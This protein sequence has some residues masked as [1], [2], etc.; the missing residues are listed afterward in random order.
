MTSITLCCW[1]RTE[2]LTRVLQSLATSCVQPYE[3]IVVDDASKN[4]DVLTLVYH[5]QKLFVEQLKVPF[6]VF[7]NEVNRGHAASQNFAMDNAVGDVL[8][9]LEDDT[10]C[11]TEGWNLAM[12]KFLQDHPEVGQV[13]PEGS[14]R[15][16]WIPRGPYNEFAWG[17]GALWAIRKDVYQKAGGWDESLRHQV[18]PDHNLRVRMAG[19]R[20]GEISGIRMIHLGEGDQHDTFKRQAQIICGV[21]AMLCKWNQRFLGDAWDYDSLWSMSWDDFPANAR[22]RRELAAWFAAEAEKL[23]DRYRGL[24]SL[25]DDP[26][27]ANAVPEEVKKAHAQLSEMRLN[28]TTRP[29]KF[30]SHWGAYELIN[31]VRPQSREREPELINLMKNN[32]HFKFVDR[33]PQQLRDLAKR[34]NYN[35]TEEELTKMLKATPSS[36]TWKSIPRYDR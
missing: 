4:K 25:K 5:F 13:L 8:I 24:K 28:P 17:L 30:V 7:V 31:V 16:E 19:Y 33:L 18:E 22:F 21:W 23:E 26:H 3:V 20:V 15:G 29:F 12:A 6:K 35:L 14:G 9:H 34:M 32:F 27:Y 36:Y 2:H 10:I 11:S 1:E